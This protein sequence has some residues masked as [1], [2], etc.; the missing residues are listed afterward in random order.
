MFFE[1]LIKKKLDNTIAIIKTSSSLNVVFLMLTI[2]IL[3]LA[4]MSKIAGCR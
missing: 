3:Q 2:V 4:I 1:C